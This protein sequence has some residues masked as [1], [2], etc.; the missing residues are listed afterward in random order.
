MELWIQLSHGCVQLPLH[1][2]RRL[3]HEGACAPGRTGQHRDR[4]AREWKR[5]RAWLW[6]RWRCSREPSAAAAVDR[7]DPVHPRLRA[8]LRKDRLRTLHRQQ[9]RPRLVP[10]AHIVLRN[11]KRAM[12]LSLEARRRKQNCGGDEGAGPRADQ[13]GGT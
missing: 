11:H 13:G 1:V 4:C 5:R 6:W 9:H 7:A 8:A 10:Q 12:Q 3:G 2:L